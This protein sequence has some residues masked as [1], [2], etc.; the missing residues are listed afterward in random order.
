MALE[1]GNGN[2]D[3]CIMV[4]D[5]VMAVNPSLNDIEGINV[6]GCCHLFV[7]D[8]SETTLENLAESIRYIKN[9]GKSDYRICVYYPG[10]EVV[11]KLADCGVARADYT[12]YINLWDSI[13][14]DGSSKET[15]YYFKKNGKRYVVELTMEDEF[16]HV[17]E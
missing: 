2:M 7:T 3:A 5:D 11:D 13:Y 17:Y 8:L 12:H 1:V 4:G 15:E 9:Q 6:R 14:S 16:H 10:E